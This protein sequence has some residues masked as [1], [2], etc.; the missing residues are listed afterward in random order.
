MLCALQERHFATEVVE[1]G[2][3]WPRRFEALIASRE[4]I[5]DQRVALEWAAESGDVLLGL[6]LCQTSTGLL[7]LGGNLREIVG[8]IERLLSLDTT[9]VPAEQIAHAM[10]YLAYGLEAKDELS[11]S[12]ETATRSL[13]EMAPDDDF[14]RCV[15]HNLVVVVLLRMGRAEEA[16]HHAEEGLTVATR[17]GDRWNQAASLAGLSAVAL[18]RGRLREAQRHGEEA[19]ARAA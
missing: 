9:G 7:P 17:S 11:R 6:R 14:P 2:V 5:D 18:V 10:A 19:L 13:A 12:L 16:A 3:P 4:L 8:W 15:M 1:P